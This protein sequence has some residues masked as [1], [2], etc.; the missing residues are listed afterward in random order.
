VLRLEP[1]V[2][3]KQLAAIAPHLAVSRVQ[4]ATGATRVS[5]WSCWRPGDRTS[6]V[7][8][9]HSLGKPAFGQVARH[10]AASRCVGG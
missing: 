4:A 6:P 7:E 10:A 8:R 5:A 1:H 3:A 9:R 2:G